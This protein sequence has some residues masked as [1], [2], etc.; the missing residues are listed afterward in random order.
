MT[1]L[2]STAP[3]RGY[4]KRL[5]ALG[6]A[7]TAAFCAI[8]AAG[9]WESRSRDREQA[10]LA[11]SNIVASMSSEIQRNLE[12][13][14]LSLDAVADGLKLP[15]IGTIRS[16][17]RQ[18]VLF[19]RASTAKDMGSIFVLDKD[20]TLIFD[21]RILNPLPEDH[22]ERDYFAVQKL[23]P[24]SGLYVSAP[25]RAVDGHY[26]AISRAISDAEG[27]FVGAVV[28][29][30]R[31]SYF[32]AIFNEL[33]LGP[34]DTISL[35]RESGAMIMRAPSMPELIGRNMAKSAVFVQIA[36]RPS[37]SFE[38]AGTV[39]GVQR[40]FV[41]RRIGEYP[42]IL[43]YNLATDDIYANWRHKA[44]QFGALILA[45]CAI[46]L[47]LLVFLARTLKQRGDAEARL[48]TMASTDSLT[49]LLNRRALDEAFEREWRR[50]L[51]TRTPVA[52]L[53]LDADGFKAYN[54]VFGH[55]A[56]DAALAAI[57]DCISGCARRA[58]DVCARYGGEEFAV[59]LA[60][61]TIDEA[62]ARAEAIRESVRVLR[63]QQ[64]G[65]PDSTPTVSIG[66]ASMIPRPGLE[67]R[68]LVK[69]ADSA[70]YEAKAT[71]RNR[72]A[73]ANRLALVASEAAAA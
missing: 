60:G 50:A 35:V 14:S 68:D 44:W 54:D 39:D 11:A 45:L 16:E 70:L 33:K 20:G 53:M 61:L 22:A 31:L 8:F 57:A 56:G 72:V 69:A 10:S 6:V 59:L 5:I 13:Y 3:K 66:A 47:A 23:N 58:E 36:A 37:G 12:L 7:I 64:Q 48:E 30:M 71:G 1:N 38:D 51:R 2:G 62:V 25:W 49:G 29:T 26:I 19:D 63:A 73:A 18:H 32:S 46:N 17:L 41:F 65:R 28:G 9:L 15:D 4:G 21:S 34:R 43:S 40:L 42:L 67:Y 55:Q 24:R 27:H 52:L